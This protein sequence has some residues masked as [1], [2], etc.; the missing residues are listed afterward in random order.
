MSSATAV[1]SY[2]GV[3]ELAECTWEPSA[4]MLLFF[5]ARERMKETSQVKVRPFKTGALRHRA[6]DGSRQGP[7]PR[8]AWRFQSQRQVGGPTKTARKRAH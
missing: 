6:S 2:W 8:K 1:H 3:L 7:L 5:F 4:D